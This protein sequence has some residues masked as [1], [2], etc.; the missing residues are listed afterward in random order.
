MEC[1]ECVQGPEGLEV[2]MDK[3]KKM[4]RAERVLELVRKHALLITL[5]LSILHVSVA[6][7][8]TRDSGGADIFTSLAV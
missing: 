4:S 8:H 2:A 3:V 7:V 1:T 5:I 6:L